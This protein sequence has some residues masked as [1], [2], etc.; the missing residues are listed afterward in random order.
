MTQSVN[1][2]TLEAPSRKINSEYRR[3]NEIG[4]IMGDR[5]NCAVISIASALDLQYS[6]VFELL[7]RNGRVKGKGTMDDVIYDS[8]R[9]LGVAWDHQY[10]SPMMRDYK[11]SKTMTFNN[12][13][14][15][16]DKNKVYLLMSRS[17]VATMKY[18]EMV[19]WAKGRK[20]RVDEVIELR[21]K[22]QEK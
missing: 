8:L 14:R 19:D 2:I 13:R 7:E 11:Y 9:M 15:V 10:A 17:H 1:E 12:A 22:Q 4:K 20:I 21:F 18:G 16:L 3:L 6:T 5:K